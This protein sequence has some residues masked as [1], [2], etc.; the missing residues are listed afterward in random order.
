MAPRI[1]TGPAPKTTAVLPAPRLTSA[2]S[3]C[4]GQALLDFPNLGQ[5]FFRNGKGLDQH[6][7][8]AES[9]RH[10]VQVSLIFDEI[11]RHETVGH[12]DAAFGKVPSE[13]EILAG[14]AARRAMIM[15]TRPADCRHDQIPRLEL[16][17]SGRDLDHFAHRFVS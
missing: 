2:A 6:G 12:L 13:A 5:S 17:H 15:R 9:W 7:E 16:R 8:I 4:P 10:D 14:I 1:P 11:L 3:V